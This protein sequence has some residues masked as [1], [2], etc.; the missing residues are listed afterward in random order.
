MH[1]YFIVCCTRL[2][3]WQ[4]RCYRASR[5]LCSNY[6]SVKLFDCFL[7][8]IIFYILDGRWDKSFFFCYTDRYPWDC[9]KSVLCC[10]FAINSNSFSQHATS[11]WQFFCQFF[12]EKP[13]IVYYAVYVCI[14]S[15]ISLAEAA[16]ILQSQLG[17]D[18]AKAEH[19]VKQFDRNNDGQL[20]AAEFD[21][22]KTTV[23]D[24]WVFQSIAL[25]Y[26]PS[27]YCFLIYC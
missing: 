15:S 4:D 3:R 26:K 1:Y 13:I 18:S 16:D 19:Y 7:K 6:L 27:A 9:A 21:R 10:K 2:P 25:T 23:R 11:I 14:F 8:D 22:F 5:E 24:T 17:Y 20:C 12:S